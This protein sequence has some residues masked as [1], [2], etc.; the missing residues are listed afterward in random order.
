VDAQ[1]LQQLIRHRQQL[2]IGLRLARADH[3]GVDL[4][5]LA[6]AALLRA[7]VTEQRPVGRDLQRRILLPAVGEEGA[8]DPGGEFGAQGQ[9]F[10]AAVVEGIHFFRH[11]IGRLT[12]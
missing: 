11:H 8:R 6:V 4:V 2:N 9:R 12:Q 7:F 3:F 5:E 1:F 10:P